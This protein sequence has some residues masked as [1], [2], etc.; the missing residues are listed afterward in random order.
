MS[1]AFEHLSREGKLNKII[2]HLQSPFGYPVPASWVEWLFEEQARKQQ[3][4]VTA[5]GEILELFAGG[6]LSVAEA[7]E[8][9]EKAFGGEKHG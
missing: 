6:Y 2:E 9:L 7:I 4:E 5:P 3:D 1:A 8:A